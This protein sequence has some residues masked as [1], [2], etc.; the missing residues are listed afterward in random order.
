MLKD[1][2]EAVGL[3]QRSYADGDEATAR[4]MIGAARSMLGM[5]DERFQVAGGQSSRALLRETDA[6]LKAIELSAAV[7]PAMFESW[8][9]KWPARDHALLAAEPRSFFSET[10]IRRQLGER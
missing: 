6:D 10:M 3:A 1:V 2:D 8:K 5:I 4:L 9:T 7:V